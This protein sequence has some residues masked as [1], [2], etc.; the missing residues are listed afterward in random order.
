MHSIP[1]TEAKNRFGEL[2]EA[3]YREPVAISKQGRTVA[4]MLS[5]S[6]YEE[7]HQKAMHETQSPAISGILDWLDRHPPKGTPIN[8]RDYTQHLNE[9]FA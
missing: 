1:A 3:V 8:E 2:L 5:I 9:K 4:V 7:M 6:V